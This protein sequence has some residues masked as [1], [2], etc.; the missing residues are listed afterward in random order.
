MRTYTEPVYNHPEGIAQRSDLNPAKIG[1]STKH[2]YKP[3]RKF[4]R[5]IS[6]VMLRNGCIIDRSLAIFDHDK[7][8]PTERWGRKASGLRTMTL[9]QRGCQNES[10]IVALVRSK[11][12]RKIVQ[13]RSLRQAVTR[14][15][16]GAV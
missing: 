14:E 11:T 1:F 13:H 7:G 2:N 3:V 10:A 9:R 12:L 5:C 4:I 6:N 8:K 15:L 16:Y